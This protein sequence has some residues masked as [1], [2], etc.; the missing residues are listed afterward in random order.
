MYLI[1]EQMKVIQKQLKLGKEQYY[2]KHLSI[3]NVFLPTE[4]T[5]KEIEVIANFMSLEGDIAKERFGTSA[6]KLVMEQMNIS[7]GGL[8]NYMKSLKN[9]G[10]IIEND[11]STTILPIL[12]PDSTEQG[13]MFKLVKG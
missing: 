7:P 11:D 3:V 1:K 6:R 13:Y 2:I 4:L 9:K 8:G 10:F 5:P 12:H